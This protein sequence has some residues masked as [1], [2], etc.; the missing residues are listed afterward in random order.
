MDPDPFPIDQSTDMW[1][2]RQGCAEVMP[3]LH[4]ARFTAYSSFDTHTSQLPALSSN[5]GKTRQQPEHVIREDMYFLN[6]A[7]HCDLLAKQKVLE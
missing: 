7:C 6:G 2:H 3:S 5:G 1:S 4:Q